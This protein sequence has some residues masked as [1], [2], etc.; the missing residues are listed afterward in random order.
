MACAYPRLK[1]YLNDEMVNMNKPVKVHYQW[2]TLFET[3]VKRKAACLA[4]TL[5]ERG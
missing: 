4:R 1:V 5:K 2:K 3:K